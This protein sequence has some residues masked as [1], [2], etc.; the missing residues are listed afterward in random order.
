M[1]DPRSLLDPT[2]DA[3]R[4][5]ARRGY[6]LDEEHLGKLL[7][8]RST[9]IQAGDAARADSKRIASEVQAAGRRGEDTTELVEQARAL[10]TRIHEI[11]E[12]ERELET[13]LQ[14]FLLWIPNLPE[15]RCPDGDSEE[16]AEE[17]KRWGTPPVFDHDPLDHVELGERLGIIDLTRA[18]KLSG[19]RF[20]VLSGAGAAL[21]RG[22]AAFF[23]ALHTERH[24]YV[25]YSLP[26]LVTRQTMTGSGQLPKFEEELFKT[27]AGDRELFLIPTAE[28]PLANLYAGEV[29]KVADLPRALTAHTPCFRSEAGS[30]GR[31]TRGMIRVH[32]FSKVELVRVCHPDRSS[33]ELDVMLGH[34]ETC[35][36]ELG[37][38]Y[39]V[40]ALPAGDISFGARFT[41][42]LEAW[43][44]GQQRYREISSV[45][46]CGTFQARRSGIRFV[47][48]DKKRSFAATLNGS[49]LPIGRTLVAILEQYQQPDGSVLIPE[50]LVPYVG[51]DRINVDG[52][53]R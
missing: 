15:D 31:D 17:L 36:Q 24:G 50:C 34:A 43:L 35:L 53:T 49:G 29:L 5:L 12:Q 52:S 30:H 2:T 46:D 21:E 48:E 27:S 4:K 20:A 1:H 23:I 11:E 26:S 25:E 42:D 44:P 14:E 9:A 28:V 33:A 18:T 16:Q 51:F 19:P 10:K 37:L 38:A 32:E 41:Y 47:D 13:E 39:R 40:I 22:L 45:S 6:D 3:K 7:A 8:R